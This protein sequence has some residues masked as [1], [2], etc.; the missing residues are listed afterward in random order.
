[1]KVRVVTVSGV[2][3][4]FFTSSYTVVVWGLGWGGI[5]FD[6]FAEKVEDVMFLG[7]S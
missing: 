2:T 1:M 4:T 5:A 6:F 3:W 7:G